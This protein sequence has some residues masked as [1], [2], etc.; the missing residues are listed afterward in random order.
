MNDMRIHSTWAYLMNDIG[1]REWDRE[2]QQ[3]W[4]VTICIRLLNS[5]QLINRMN[6]V[7]EFNELMED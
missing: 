2:K 4:A 7:R 1:Y 6:V 5:R 3:T